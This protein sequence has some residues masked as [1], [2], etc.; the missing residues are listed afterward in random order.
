M[1]WGGL[2][3]GTL[4]LTYMGSEPQKQGGAVG[5]GEEVGRSGISPGGNIS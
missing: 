1:H 4:L 5:E 2:G 3:A